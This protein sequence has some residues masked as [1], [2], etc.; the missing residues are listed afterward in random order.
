MEA[1]TMNDNT[2]TKTSHGTWKATR[3]RAQN[4]LEYAIVVAVIVLALVGKLTDIAAKIG[5]L[6]DGIAKGIGGVTVQ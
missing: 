5:G 6:L 3:Q 1:E 4:T 2:P